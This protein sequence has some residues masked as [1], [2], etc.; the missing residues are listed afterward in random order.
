MMTPYMLCLLLASRTATQYEIA[1]ALG[2]WFWQPDLDGF[3]N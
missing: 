2:L 3:V 1:L